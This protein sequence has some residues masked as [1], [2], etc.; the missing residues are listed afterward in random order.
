MVRGT[1]KGPSYPGASLRAGRG[2][3]GKR[4]TARCGGST[5]VVLAVRR[6]PAPLRLL[7]A[8][9]AVV[10]LV[11]ASGCGGGDS[12]QG[13]ALLRRGFDESIGSA[14]ASIDLTAQL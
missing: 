9:A 1:M 2:V 3:R 6:L 8:L 7:A 12:Q 14:T 13:R 11:I 5:L 4:G 10:L